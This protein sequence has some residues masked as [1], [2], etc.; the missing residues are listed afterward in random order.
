MKRLKPLEVVPVHL[1]AAEAQRSHDVAGLPRG[2]A[3]N[4]RGGGENVCFKATGVDNQET[5]MI[6]DLIEEFE[7]TLKPIFF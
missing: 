5:W 1:H 2:F 7:Q 6:L 4:P 3:Q